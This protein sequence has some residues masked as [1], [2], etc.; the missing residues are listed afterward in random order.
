MSGLNIRSD[1][2]DLNTNHPIYY[3]HI[4]IFIRKYSIVAHG[5]KVRTLFVEFDIEKNKMEIYCN[6]LLEPFYVNYIKRKNFSAT[7][8]KNVYIINF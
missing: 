3:T 1:R 8:K 7:K 4:N 2:Y 5:Y 6:R